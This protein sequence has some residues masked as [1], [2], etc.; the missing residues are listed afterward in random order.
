MKVISKKW[1]EK[2]YIELNWSMQRCAD[3]RD[4]D[5]SYISDL[6]K[7][8]H[9]KRITNR[10]ENGYLNT[11]PKVKLSSNSSILDIIAIANRKVS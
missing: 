10:A 7:R 5:K 9:I 2:H 3:K 8:Y 4:V 11:I 1:L 6:L